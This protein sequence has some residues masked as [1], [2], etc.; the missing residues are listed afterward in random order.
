MTDYEIEKKLREI[1]NK[2]DKQITSI[3]EKQAL[4]NIRAVKAEMMLAEGE[5]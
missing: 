4:E 2:V 3:T 5:L 1:K